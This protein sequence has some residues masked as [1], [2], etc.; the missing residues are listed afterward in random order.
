M[1][2]YGNLIFVDEPRCES[3]GTEQ[4]MGSEILVESVSEQNNCLEAHLL[5]RNVDL[6]S[7]GDGSPG[8]CR[9]DN[10]G[11]VSC[12]EVMEL[13]TG[14]RDGLAG[15]GESTSVMEPEDF[16]NSEYGINRC[17]LDENQNDGDGC[18]NIE[19]GRMQLKEG[20]CREDGFAGPF[21][22]CKVPSEVIPPTGSPGNGIQ[23]DEHRDDKSANRLSSEGM[24]EV[25][26]EKGELPLEFVDIDV[27]RD[28]NIFSCN[29]LE[30]ANEK[31]VALTGMEAGGLC[32]GTSPAQDGGMPSEVSNTGD[33]VT[34]CN[35]NKEH[36]DDNGV[37]G[38][39]GLSTEKSTEV[40]EACNQMLPSLSFQRSLED[41][42]MPNSLSNFAQQSD[43]RSNNTVDGSLAD[44]ATEFMEEKSNVMT[45]KEAEIHTQISPVKVNVSC[46]KENS[47][48]VAPN[49]IIEN[50]VPPQ[51]C[52]AFSIANNSVDGHYADSVTEVVDMKSN[53][54]DACNQTLPPDLLSVCTQENDQSSDKVKECVEQKVD[55]TTDMRVETGT[56]I[57]LKE[58]KASNL[59]KDSA[60][61]FPNST[62]ENSVPLQLHQPFDIVSNDS[63]KTVDVPDINDSPGHVE[64]STSFDHSGLMDHE[65]N[66]NFRVEFFSKTNFSEIIALPAQRSGRSRKTPTK[67]APRKRRNASK[68]LQPLGS[69]ESVFKGAGRKRSCLSKPPR[70]STW[71]LLGSV[72]QSFEESNGLQVHQVCQGQNE[73][74]QKRRGGR[75]SGK[76]KQSVASG[77]F[78]GSRG[79]S[80]NHVR[81]KVKFGK[82]VDKNLLY[83]KAAEFVDTS[84]CANSIQIVN[85]V[86]GNWRQEATVRKCQHT[87]K[88]LEKDETCQDGELANKDLET[89]SV[90][91]ISAE[92]EIQ[93][94]LVVPSHA[95]AISSGGSVGSSYRD[96]GTSPDSEVINLIPEAHVEARPQEDSHGTDLTSDK[97][98]S[99]SG[100]FISS[101]RGKKKHKLPYAGNCVPE[102]GSP[103]P[104]PVSTMRAKPS[105]R[106]GCR[107]N[108]SQDICSGETFTSSP[109]AKASTNS[110]SDRDL[111]V[112][113]LCLSGGSD[114]GVERGAEAETDC[115]L[116]VGLGL[117]NSQNMLPSSNTKGQKPPKGKSRGSDSASKRSNTRKPREKEQKSVNK[118]KVKEDKQLACK[119]ESLPESGDPL[120]DA[121]TSHV[122]ECM[123]VPNLD[124]VPVD[125]DKQY[126]PPRNAWVLCDACNKWRRIPA[127]LADFIDETKCTWTCRENQDRNFADCSIS[128]EKSNAEINSELEISDASGEEDA[129]GTRL[130]YKTLECRRPSVSQQ[131]VASIKTN[132]FLHRNR[133]NQSIDEIMVC[134]CKLP[135]DGQLGCG[136]DCLNRML[137]IEC[138]RGTCPCGDLCSN[139]QFQKRRYSKLEKFRSGKKGFGLRSLE[140]ICKGQFLIE[141]V[142]EVLDTHAYEARQKEYAVKGH[143]HFYFMT[144]N[145]SE[146]IDACAK[147]NLGRFINHSCDPNCRT[148]KWMV[149]GEVCIGLFALRDIKK[150]EEVTFDYNFVRVIGAAA[151]KCYCGSPQCQ[152]YIGGDPLNTEIIVQDDSDEEYVEPVMIAEDGVAEDS[153]GNAVARLDSLDGAIIQ[154]EESASTNKDI[155]KST[156]SVGKLEITTQREES[157]ELQHLLPSFVQPVEAFQQTE[158]VTSRS[159]PVVRQEVFREKETTEKSSVSFERP[160][161][162]SPTK[163]ISKPLSDDIDANKN[164]KFNTIED[165][166]LSSKVHRN[167]K[168]SRSSSSV[169]KG[170]VRSTPLNTNKIQVVANKSHVLPFKPKR[171]IEGSVEEKLNELLDVDG[172]ISKRKDSTKGYLKLLFLTAQSGDSGSGEAIKSNRDLSIILD[173]L[174]KTKSRT[175]L[176][177]IINKNGL[178]MLHNIMKMCRR[179]FNKIPILRKLLKVL[180]YLAEK[181]QI[182]TQEHITGGPP[183]PGME[184]FTES[185]LSLTEHGDKR[186]HDIARNFRNRWIPKAFRRHSFVDRDDGKME[187]NRS[188]NYNRF[189]TTHD[190]WRDQ[191]GRSTEVADNA[192]QSVVKTPT[193]ASTVILDGSST[194]ST[195]GCAT[196]E[197][198]VR[199]RKSR[200]DQPAVTVPD[201]SSLPNKE[202]KIESKQLESS[203][204]PRIGDVTSHPEKGSREGR[205]CTSTVHDLCQQVGADVVYDGKQNI[206]EDVPPGF[207]SCL[208]TPVVSSTSS[209]IGHPQAKFV[210]R[211]PVSYGIPLSIM[212]QYGTPH[213]ESVDT[214]VVAPGMPFHPFPPLPPCPRRKKDPSHDVNHVSSV[215][216]ASEGQQASCVATNCHSEESSPSTT[217]ATQAD[218]GTSCANNQLGTKRQRESSYEAPLGRR[219]FKQQKWNHAKPRLPWVRDRNGWGCNGNNFRGG[220]N[221]IGVG[222][223]GNELRTPYCSEDI[224]YRVEKAGNNVNQQSHHH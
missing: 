204:L 51:S 174:L 203:P 24:M 73:G 109:G 147:G 156:I 170:K 181:P 35:W 175:V 78:Q 188:S 148:E 215:N 126:V 21:D 25:M 76:Q 60:G 32:N 193:S 15:G 163:V 50:S 206:P 117:H 86:E 3:F 179:D 94:C 196:S 91:E 102:D 9:N 178:R 85:V 30:A 197:T 202:Q 132:Q 43:P 19:S 37:S 189:S 46:L 221:S 71:G 29:S 27:C 75:R 4:Q 180:E 11:C 92:D 16:L 128:Q 59:T 20:W 123:G 122:V 100:D 38:V 56:Q 113:P 129:S 1:A 36:I 80:T 26:E 6:A 153:R 69:V 14:D 130:H 133:K 58:E 142:G 223:V 169:K 64:S 54:V 154:R 183:C 200:W 207:S 182:L 125:L 79:T 155:D 222:T 198:K 8:F 205:N 171:S 103:C 68:V 138:V 34:N 159:T 186:V 212:Q 135:K 31:S 98:L 168:T 140:Y 143:R 184:S 44:R 97:V 87:N 49:C 77:N 111:S 106:D 88:K 61:L 124:V 105:T 65:G 39:S 141:Y 216:Q 211:L 145:T 108:G 52:D 114:H 22:D 190:N 112:E 158:D 167:V 121:N 23:L 131:N 99:A 192:K 146:V 2:S 47:S 67:K 224:S 151:K 127:E 53:I 209:V 176:I 17:G 7:E 149:N 160:E 41:L 33:L 213:A 119:V 161:I 120:A 84:A 18:S 214:W 134:H 210:S 5:D 152:G 185:I 218:F 110:S 28:Y 165:V 136:E 95:I 12:S 83:N 82:E 208:N 177:D 166:Q 164:S 144:L 93:N 220:T 57:L 81:L 70:S 13:G 191:S 157:V 187:F 55:G 116:D 10:A 115:I 201:P 74:S 118:K 137:N 104:C 194:P 195:G 150:G 96:P 42:H 199:K 62:I 72:T 45:E 66:D 139:Q 101:K 90:S 40:S 63:S 217:G 172:G 173:A 48:N 89:V 162:T 107:Q 219:Y